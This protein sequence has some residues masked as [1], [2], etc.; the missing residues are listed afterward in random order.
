M[1][2]KKYKQREGKA[3]SKIFKNDE[4]V[5]EIWCR[6]EKSGGKVEKKKHLLAIKAH[7]FYF[8]TSSGEG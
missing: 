3:G 8:I 1:E 7:F 5:S 2:R 4:K 6:G